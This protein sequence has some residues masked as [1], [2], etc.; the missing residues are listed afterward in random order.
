MSTLTHNL[1]LR[2]LSHTNR[3]ILPVSSLSSLVRPSVERVLLVKAK[4][5]QLYVNFEKWDMT[6]F[7]WFPLLQNWVMFDGNYDSGKLRQNVKWEVLNNTHLCHLYFS[8]SYADSF[9]YFKQASSFLLLIFKSL[10]FLKAGTKTNKQKSY[11]Y[12][13]IIT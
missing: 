7:S 4:Q 11:I 2:H 10:A 13:S 6:N 9:G 3:I 1:N 5:F 12:I 8:L